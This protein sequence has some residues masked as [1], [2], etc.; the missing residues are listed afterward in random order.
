MSKHKISR[1]YND[2]DQHLEKV[3]IEQPA[4]IMRDGSERWIESTHAKI[5]EKAVIDCDFEIEIDMEELLIEAAWRCRNN[6]SGKSR[7]LGGII[8][9]K[10]T[11][12]EREVTERIDKPIPEGWKEKQS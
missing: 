3:Q 5:I 8:K 11:R 9:V 10:R 2:R 1:R 6:K 4:N 12:R 7:L